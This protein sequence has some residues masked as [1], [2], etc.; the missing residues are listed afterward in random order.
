MRILSDGTVVK[1]GVGHKLH[2]SYFYVFDVESEYSHIVRHHF[3]V[4]IVLV[5]VV[6]LVLHQALPGVVVETDFDVVEP[7]CVVIADAGV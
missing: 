2:F 4:L 6:V 3:I 7:D 1:V 5:L